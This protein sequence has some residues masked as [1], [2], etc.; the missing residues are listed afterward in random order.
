M[1]L[2]FWDLNLKEQ[3]FSHETENLQKICLRTTKDVKVGILKLRNSIMWIHMH[4]VKCMV[5]IQCYLNR[6][7]DCH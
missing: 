7:S 1:D 6:D 4:V 3:T 2:V 5:V